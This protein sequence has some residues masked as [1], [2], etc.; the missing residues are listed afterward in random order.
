MNQ[1]DRTG[2]KSY[3]GKGPQQTRNDRAILALLENPTVEKAAAAINVHQSTLYRWLKKRDFRDKLSEARNAAF[4]QGIASLQ[5]ASHV[6]AGRLVALAT[7]KDT[8]GT[9]A[10]AACN[11][12]LNHGARSFQWDLFE[13]RLKLEELAEQREKNKGSQDRAM[14]EEVIANAKRP[15]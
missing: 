4:S 3:N 15:V 2:K 6:A 8:P 7:D 13:A 9:V 1:S 14:L 5:Q 11:S 12:I 10:V